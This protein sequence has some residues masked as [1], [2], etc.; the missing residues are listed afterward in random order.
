MKI[1]RKENS[2]KTGEWDGAK[3]MEHE[4]RGPPHVQREKQ[5]ESREG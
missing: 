1:A 5:A 2:G 4:W 3:N